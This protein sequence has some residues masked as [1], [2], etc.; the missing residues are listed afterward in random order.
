MNKEYLKLIL[1]LLAISGYMSFKSIPIAFADYEYI[2]PQIYDYKP[3]IRIKSYIGLKSQNRI[4]FGNYGIR[5]IIGDDRLYKIIHDTHGQ[6]IFI[7]PIAKAGEVIDITIVGN[8]NNVQDLSLKILDDFG[9][10]I[11]IRS[12][13]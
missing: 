10:T 11:V 1:I 5:E 7:I 9:R 4:N 2:Q 8:N 6:N 12:K 13:L 3:N